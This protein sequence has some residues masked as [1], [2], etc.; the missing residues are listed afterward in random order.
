MMDLRAAA[1]IG[2]LQAVMVLTALVEWLGALARRRS[3]QREV[4]ATTR[5]HYAGARADPCPV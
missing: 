2:H 1:Y 4:D 3:D 5:L